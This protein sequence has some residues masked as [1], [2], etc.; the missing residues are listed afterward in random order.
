MDEV[1]TNILNL[2]FFP[3]TLTFSDVVDTSFPLPLFLFL[4]I[5]II[6]MK[7]YEILKPQYKIYPN[8]VQREPLI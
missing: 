8:Q 7:Y 2:L 4:L 5:G 3:P 6:D 1:V